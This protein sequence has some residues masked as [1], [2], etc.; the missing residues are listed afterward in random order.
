M[1]RPCNGGLKVV[2]EGSGLRQVSEEEADSRGYAQ[3]RIGYYY[4]LGLGVLPNK[5]RLYRRR[6]LLRQNDSPCRSFIVVSTKST[7]NVTAVTISWTFN[8]TKFVL[9][10]HALTIQVQ[11]ATE[12]DGQPRTFD[13]YNCELIQRQL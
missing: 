7:A 10:R 5:P 11:M 4:E 2:Q 13:A 6:K 9:D 12:G 3:Y 8:H 1:P